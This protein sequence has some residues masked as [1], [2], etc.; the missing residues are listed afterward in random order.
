MEKISSLAAP[1]KYQPRF[2]LADND[3]DSTTDGAEETRGDEHRGSKH[4]LVAPIISPLPPFR[5]VSVPQCTITTSLAFVTQR[6]I[7]SEWC[8]AASLSMI[9]G[10]HG[11]DVPQAQIVKETWGH[12]VDL[13]GSPAQVI[14]DLNKTWTDVNGKQFLPSI[15][16]NRSMTGVTPDDI[17]DDLLAGHP[18]MIGTPSHAMVVVSMTYNNFLLGKSLVSIIVADP[19]NGN[20]RPLYPDEAMRVNFMARVATTPIKSDNRAGSLVPRKE[21]K[22][23]KNG[24]QDEPSSVKPEQNNCNYGVFNNQC[25]LTISSHLKEQKIEGKHGKWTAPIS[26][27]LQSKGYQVSQAQIA[28]TALKDATGEVPTPDLRKYLNKEFTDDRGQ[29]FRLEIKVLPFDLNYYGSIDALTDEIKDDRPP[30]LV[31][32][33]GRAFVAASFLY[34]PDEETGEKTNLT[35]VS[36]APSKDGCF[37]RFL[38][39]KDLSQITHIIT[40]K[41][42]PVKIN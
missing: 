22:T 29:K 39:K 15:P 9:F 32:L 20:V 25:L 11:Y 5:F 37:A 35:V 38:R 21:E 27:I 24:E 26:M 6:Q 30:I 18:L 3:Q 40:L 33:W 14:K 2:R 19:A 13:P 1:Q 10:A 28:D 42:V 36:F 8:W 12:I 41:I 7:W 16:K 17:E 31:D 23:E 34:T 4:C